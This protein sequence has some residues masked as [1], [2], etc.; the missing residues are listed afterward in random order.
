MAKFGQKTEIWLLIIRLNGKCFVWATGVGVYARMHFGGMHSLYVQ[1]PHAK[2][3]SEM[4]GGAD[5][6]LPIRKKTFRNVKSKF[7]YE[8]LFLL[9]T[10]KLF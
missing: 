9:D 5:S 10:S 7:G 6:N 2:P 3:T 4:A 1:T 8:K